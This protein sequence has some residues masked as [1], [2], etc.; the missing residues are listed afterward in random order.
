M[1]WL[2]NNV[3]AL[4]PL[5]C[6]SPFSHEGAAHTF[7]DLEKSA[8]HFKHTIKCMRK[9]RKSP[10]IMSEFTQSISS[11]CC[12]SVKSHLGNVFWGIFFL[13]QMP[14]QSAQK[15]KIKCSQV[16]ARHCR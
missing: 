9:S 12:F 4:V 16:K 7:L 5:S 14:F 1:N 6:S 8:Y 2:L 15:A 10:K 3:A 11:R 13:K